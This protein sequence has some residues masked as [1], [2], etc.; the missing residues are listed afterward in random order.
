M[1]GGT[2]A[3]GTLQGRHP[4]RK[5]SPSRSRSCTT[6]AV[7]G[8]RRTSR[9]TSTHSHTVHAHKG[10]TVAALSSGATATTSGKRP[11]SYDPRW[12]AHKPLTPAHP[13]NDNEGDT[14]VARPQH[15]GPRAARK[16]HN[17]PRFP[18]VRAVHEAPNQHQFSEPNAE[19]GVSAP[20]H[21]GVARSWLDGPEQPPRHFP[22]I[23]APEFQKR[24]VS[25][26]DPIPTNQ[27]I[28]VLTSQVVLGGNA[29]TNNNIIVFDRA[30][31][32]AA[33]S[34]VAPPQRGDIPTAAPA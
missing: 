27:Q 26:G 24:D 8:G 3:A 31:L 12:A 10:S 18:Y 21:L 16:P 6:G 30:Y 23:K 34:T 4:S 7:H 28:E 25:D 14:I 1:A 17:L 20:R 13:S 29:S 9:S 11:H 5:S 19:S 2:K 33:F 22:K 32:A 15:S